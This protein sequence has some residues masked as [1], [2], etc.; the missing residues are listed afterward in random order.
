[1]KK[2]YIF[3]VYWMISHQTLKAQSPN[4][5]YPQNSYNLA[6]NNPVTPII[7]SNSGGYIGFVVSTFAGSG[8]AGFV[9]GAGDNACFSSPIGIDAGTTTN[10]FLFVCDYNNNAIRTISST[11]VV[12]T[13]AGNGAPGFNNAIGLNA[14]F[15]G[16]LG[17]YTDGMDNAYVGDFTNQR[18]RKVSYI[19]EVTTAAGSGSIGSLDTYAANSTF[20][21]PS[22][23]DRYDDNTGSPNIFVADFYNGKIRQIGQNGYVSTVA[24]SGIS[25]VGNLTNPSDLIVR[26]N[27]LDYGNIYVADFGDNMIKSVKIGNPGYGNIT[28]VAGTG[29]V[30]W[31]DGTASQAKF[32]KPSAIDIDY[33]GAIYVTD[34]D[35]HCVR[36]IFNGYVSTIAGNGTAGFADGV[37]NLAQFNN[38]NG[39]AVSNAI[40]VSDMS[41]H[42]IR[43]IAFTGSYSISPTLPAGLVFDTKTGMISGTPMVTS[44][45]T[46]YTITATNPSGTSTAIIT[47]SITTLQA[48][49]QTLKEYVVYPNP[50]HDGVYIDTQN[51]VTMPDRIL[52]RDFTGKVL[53]DK[54]GFVPYISFNQL[55]AGVYLIELHSG[56]KKWSQ[57]IIKN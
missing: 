28:V 29:Q 51:S 19:G 15:N 7:P 30:G 44:P 25:N 2:A 16:P 55:S 1:M 36:R 50:V 42:K 52:V 20:N 47:I 14:K 57:R 41:N 45:S 8:T 18:I 31:V 6:V 10:K 4:I 56:D 22:G 48:D 35:N 33:E 37:G 34:R 13:L 54:M 49:T 27:N 12:S 39:I 3:L 38:P 5:S 24:G 43:K 40:Y 46:N 53:I 21:G 32:N 17:I 11:G 26:V 23:I 9:N